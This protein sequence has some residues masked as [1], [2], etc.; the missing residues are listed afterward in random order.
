MKGDWKEMPKAKIRDIISE[1]IADIRQ[2]LDLRGL[3]SPPILL[4][5]S[6]T[7]TSI[8]S[9]DEIDQQRPSGRKRG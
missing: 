2:Q 8:G 3:S 1:S 7:E 9:T 4:H 6:E 5:A